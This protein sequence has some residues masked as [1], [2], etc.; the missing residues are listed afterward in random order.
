M[1]ISLAFR[2]CLW[3]KWLISIFRALRIKSTS[4]TLSLT[5]NVTSCGLVR[6]RRNVIWRLKKEIYRWISCH[7][8]LL[9]NLKICLFY[10]ISSN[11]PLVWKFWNNFF[12]IDEARLWWSPRQ[13]LVFKNEVRTRIKII[14]CISFRVSSLCR[15]LKVVLFFKYRLRSQDRVCGT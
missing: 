10:F 14:W 13:L 5:Y 11:L 6:S 7:I 4:F 8:A 9:I 12:S 15:Q 2:G 3:Q 1:N